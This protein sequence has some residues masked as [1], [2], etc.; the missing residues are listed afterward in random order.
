M[1]PSPFPATHPSDVETG[2]VGL[3]EGG[4]VWDKTVQVEF[5]R[6]VSEEGKAQWE[7]ED[8]ESG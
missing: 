6:C 4:A 2:A 3:V 8:V 1:Y 7:G 5:L